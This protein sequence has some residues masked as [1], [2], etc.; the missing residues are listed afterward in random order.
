MLEGKVDQHEIIF[1]TT[2]NNL[3]FEDVDF[4]SYWPEVTII[5]L[6]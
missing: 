2:Y 1:L 4:G 5:D 6:P 3:I